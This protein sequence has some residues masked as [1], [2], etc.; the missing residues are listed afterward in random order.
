MCV[1]QW[2][3]KV[4]IT[5]LWGELWHTPPAV[6]TPQTHTQ[7]GAFHPISLIRSRRP[8]GARPKLA[9]AGRVCVNVWGSVP[10]FIFAVRGLPS[11]VADR[12]KPAGRLWLYRDGGFGSEFNTFGLLK[13][14]SSDV[15]SSKLLRCKEAKLLIWP[16]VQSIRWI[17]GSWV[18]FLCQD[19]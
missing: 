3:W 19:V 1:V 11:L 18:V 14:N 16:Y 17:S 4:G 9:R 8:W 15:P 10:R 12:L 7:A 2:D 13:H 5:E 6:Y